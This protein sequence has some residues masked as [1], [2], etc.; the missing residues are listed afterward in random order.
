MLW[1]GGPSGRGRHSVPT[2]V[3]AVLPVE[4][5]MVL[6]VCVCVLSNAWVWVWVWV[7]MLWEALDVLRGRDVN[8]TTCA[9]CGQPHLTGVSPSC[10]S[11]TQPVAF[12]GPGGA[13]LKN[14]CERMSHRA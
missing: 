5:S 10:S 14:R 2:Q 1:V 13:R 4:C 9:G 6:C 8:L 3:G 12:V 7:G 11:S